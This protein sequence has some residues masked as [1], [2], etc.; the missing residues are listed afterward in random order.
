M[1]IIYAFHF[2]KFNNCLITFAIPSIPYHIGCTGTILVHYLIP[3]WYSMHLT[4]SCHIMYRYY[5]KMVCGLVPRWQIVIELVNLY[6]FWFNKNILSIQNYFPHW[7]IYIICW[8]NGCISFILDMIGSL[9]LILLQSKAHGQVRVGI[10]YLMHARYCLLWLV[11]LV[12]LSL[13]DGQNGV[14]WSLISHSN[15]CLIWGRAVSQYKLE[16][17]LTHN[18][19]ATKKVRYLYTDHYKKILF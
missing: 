15:R 14:R 13:K 18:L 6:V 2:I 16:F 3:Y 19:C 8:W 9:Y 1:L 4:I 12:I 5:N 17:F 11:G 7:L 10:P